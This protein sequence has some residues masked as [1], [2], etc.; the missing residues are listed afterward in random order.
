MSKVRVHNLNISLDGF[1]AGEYVTFD[2]PI[3]D[4]GALF[5]GFDGRAIHGV[6]HAD[7]PL[8][9]DRALTSTWSQGIGVEIMGRR[10]FGPQQGP[11]TDDDWRGWWGD[12]PPFLT[13]VVVMTHHPREPLHFDNG[14]SFYFVDGTAEEVLQEAIGLAGGGDVR[15]GGGPS[16]VRQ[17]LEADLVDVMH[18]VFRPVVLG[19][20][21]SLWDGL[22]GLQERF[23]IE[24]VVAA[25]GMIHQLWN[26]ERD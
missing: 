16:S 15:L 20:G 7:A 9:I 1:A 21:V 17:F 14:T 12:E 5:S 10:K 3:G 13:P 8:T 4:A 11:W 19:A 26:R 23:S 24:T 25:S 2:K 22:A 6:Q 18:L